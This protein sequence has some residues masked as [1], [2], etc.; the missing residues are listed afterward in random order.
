MKKIVNQILSKRLLYL[1]CFLAIN[2]IEFLKAT[3]N[4]DVWYVAVNLTGLAVFVMI[5]STY[6]KKD[7]INWFN[8]I[9]TLLCL[10][11]M[12]AVYWY[13]QHFPEQYFHLGQVESAFLNVWWIG[14]AARVLWKR[15]FVEKTMKVHFS[16]MGILWTAMM[17]FMIF[18]VSGKV[19]PLWFLVMFGFFY[20]TEFSD[21]DKRNLLDGMLDGTILSFFGF[22]IFA[23][24]TRPFDEV[25]YVGF[26]ANCNVVALYYLITYVMVLGKLHILHMR[27]KPFG[28]RVFYFIGAGGLLSFQIFTLCRTA[29]LA[30]IAVTGVYG[31]FVVHKLWQEK[32]RKVLLR[33]VALGLM[34]VATFLPVFY[35]IRWLPTLT[36][37]RVWFEGEYSINKVHSFDPAD[38]EKYIEL[39]EFMEQF[40]GRIVN[41]LKRADAANPLLLR[42]KAQEIEQVDI[43]EVSWTQDESARIRLTI[44]KT[45]LQNMTWYGNPPDKGFYQIGVSNYSWHAQNLWIQIGY[46]FGIPAG[47]LSIFLTIAILGK[48]FGTMMKNRENV[49]GILPL[50]VS[51]IF[52]VFGLLEVVWLPGQLILFLMFFVQ[53][54][55]L[56]N[57]Q[58]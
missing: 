4:G 53:H 11:A 33:G 39:D 40:L 1:V 46:T 17:A 41:T 48:N 42:A 51:I 44:Y 24:A 9:Y 54:P 15:I 12:V 35:T 2:L 57:V 37:Y 25:R 16:K 21:E 34:V 43:M 28:W 23:Y 27:K 38:S 20:L 8:G 6:Q 29:W 50:M 26:Y 18:S 7:M 5:A 56:C 52:F 47:I 19:W 36:H 14:I 49:Y 22:Q 58:Q 45:Y 31:I 30:S 55:G 32:W 10:A 13:K 3:Q